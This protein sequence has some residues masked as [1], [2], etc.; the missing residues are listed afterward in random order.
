MN[1]LNSVLLEGNLV[2]DPVES[3]SA[4][5]EIECTFTVV[6][7]RSCKK[8]DE[9]VKEVTTVDVKVYSTLAENCLHHLHKG[10]GVRIV[11]RL[12]QVEGNDDSGNS[13]IIIQ[14]EHVEFKPVVVPG[15]EELEK[16]V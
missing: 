7:V 6:S 2:K 4:L 10:R 11:G 15:L 8:D 5:D 1:S 9:T 12:K 3:R 16:A 14:A 13:Q